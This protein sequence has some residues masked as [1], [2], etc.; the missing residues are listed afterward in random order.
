[1]KWVTPIKKYYFVKIITNISTNHFK[2][3]F[4]SHNYCI[5]VCSVIHYHQAALR[6]STHCFVRPS[7]IWLVGWSITLSFT[8]CFLRSF[9]LTAPAQMHR[10]PQ[11]QPCPPARDWGSCVSGLVSI[12]PKHSMTPA[13]THMGNFLF[14]LPLLPPS[15]SPSPPPPLR[16]RR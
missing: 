4:I 6:D 3:Y 9:C 11:I 5:F 10:W 7:V 14:L 2:L 1:M 8:V 12:A 16:R 15:P 13:F